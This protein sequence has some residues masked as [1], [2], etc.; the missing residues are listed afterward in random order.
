MPL[1]R[2]IIWL[3]AHRFTLGRCSR[4]EIDRLIL[5]MQ[6]SVRPEQEPKNLRVRVRV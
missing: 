4:K 2:T 1:N 6:Q 3:P 5:H